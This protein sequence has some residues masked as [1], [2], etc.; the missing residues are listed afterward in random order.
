MKFVGAWSSQHGYVIVCIYRPGPTRRREPVLKT[1]EPV[2]SMRPAQRSEKPSLQFIDN[3]DPVA[4]APPRRI[5]P[6]ASIVKH[7]ENAELGM[8]VEAI[9]RCFQSGRGRPAP[10]WR[11][12]FSLE[13]QDLTFCV[14]PCRLRCGPNRLVRVPRPMHPRR[15]SNKV[16]RVVDASSCPRARAL[17]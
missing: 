8:H 2:G 10:G 14:G 3:P 16:R 12:R 15:S 1:S 9:W 4:V 11:Q 6:S 17:R 7:A 5:P 13:E